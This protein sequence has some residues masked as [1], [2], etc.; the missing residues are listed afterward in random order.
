MLTAKKIQI[1]LYEQLKV[2]INYPNDGNK[3]DKEVIT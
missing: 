2:Y 1:S 3:F